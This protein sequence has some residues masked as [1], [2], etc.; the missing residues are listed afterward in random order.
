MYQPGFGTWQHLFVE[1]ELEAGVAVEEDG[2]GST[3]S[4]LAEDLVTDMDALVDVQDAAARA[5]YLGG[6]VHRKEL[7]KG[8]VHPVDLVRSIPVPEVPFGWNRPEQAV[9]GQGFRRIAPTVRAVDK[10]PESIVRRYCRNGGNARF[11]RV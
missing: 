4:Q 5:V 7:D 2:T 10:E 9:F 11:R 1:P 3:D 6:I 8:L